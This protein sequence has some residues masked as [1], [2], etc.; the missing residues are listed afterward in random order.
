MNNI[1]KILSFGN[2]LK[3]LLTG[4]PILS[5]QKLKNIFLEPTLKLRKLL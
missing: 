3:I 4:S 2:D 1:R 5:N